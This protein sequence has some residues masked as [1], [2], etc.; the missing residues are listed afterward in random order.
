VQLSYINNIQ[1]RTQVAATLQASAV[2]QDQSARWNYIRSGYAEPQEHLWV[3][4]HLAILCIAFESHF[5]R[6]VYWGR[7]SGL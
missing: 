2:L 5:K 6:I 7:L 4:I 1:H 3:M